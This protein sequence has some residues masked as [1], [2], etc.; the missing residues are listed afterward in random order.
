MDNS[1]TGGKTYGIPFQR[2]TPVLY[3]NK[4]AFKDAGLDP[5]KAPATWDEMVSFGKKLTKK[6][7]SGN[8][9]QW[10]LRIPPRAFPTGCS[11]G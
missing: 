4:E 7:A 6:D 5:N 1:Q 2:S 8:V 9:T 3:W 11:R 10:G